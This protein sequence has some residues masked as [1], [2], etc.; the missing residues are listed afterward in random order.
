MIDKKSTAEKVAVMQAYLS[1]EA[2]EATT[3]DVSSWVEWG[4]H[5]EPT[6]NWE[7][8][9]YRV[10]EEDHTLDIPWEVVDEKWKWAAMDDDGRVYLYTGEPHPDSGQF[11][12]DTWQ[13]VAGTSFLKIRLPDTKHWD[14]T[15]TKRPEGV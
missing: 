10:K 12:E 9:D 6:W 4:T 11:V 15:L 7:K 14:K 2:L 3:D 8:C 1:G 5:Q 13:E